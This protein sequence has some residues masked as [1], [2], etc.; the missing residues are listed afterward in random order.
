MKKLFILLLACAGMARA[1]G[2][3]ITSPIPLPTY[4]V[5]PWVIQVGT[6]SYI[7]YQTIITTASFPAE[8]NLSFPQNVVCVDS[9]TVSQTVCAVSQTS[10]TYSTN[11]GTATWATG[12]ATATWVLNGG[13]G[14]SITGV[15]AGT[16]L[17]GGGTTGTVTLNLAP[18]YSSAVGIATATNAANIATL[19]LST[20]SLATSVTN[21]QT[22]TGTIQAQVNSIATSTGTLVPYSGASGYL[23][24]GNYGVSASSVTAS[25]VT[26]TNL[27][28][29]QVIETVSTQTYSGN[30]SAFTWTNGMHQVVTLSPNSGN[31]TTFVFNAP[32]GT[33]TFTLEIL[34]DGSGSRTVTWPSNVHWPAKTAPTLTTTAGALDIVSF[35]YDSVRGI[36][37]GFP[38]TNF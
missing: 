11:A 14:G 34:Q 4:N 27:S 20:I 17:T 9:P 8:P 3:Q 1:N 12:A 26:V 38:A 30:Y 6:I 32:T 29:T 23:Y 24:L 25:S 18:S 22:S 13:G 15:T 2:V 31:N 37:I 21:L 5:N 33:C 16:N 10:T 19:S 36:Y 28:L 7:G 35:L